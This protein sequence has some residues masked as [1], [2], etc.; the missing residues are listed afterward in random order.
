MLHPLRQTSIATALAQHR[1]FIA[2]KRI[3]LRFEPQARTRHLI[4]LFRIARK[5][6]RTYYPRLS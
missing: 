5:S 6:R 1:S 3:R 4:P 2:V